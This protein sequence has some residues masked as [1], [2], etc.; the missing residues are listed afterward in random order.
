MAKGEQKIGSNAD[1]K[2]LAT[3]VIKTQT[4]E[5]TKMNKILDRL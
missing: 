1:A 2:K 5:M 4:A 3:A